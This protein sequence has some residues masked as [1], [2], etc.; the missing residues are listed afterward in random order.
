M[1][2]SRENAARIVSKSAG[3]VSDVDFA[4]DI[5]R[6]WWVSR[7]LHEQLDSVNTDAIFSDLRRE[8][9][10]SEHLSYWDFAVRL[11][12]HLCRLGDGH[13]RV[14]GS[15][16]ESMVRYSSGFY[17]AVT[18]QG[19]ATV[20]APVGSGES[21]PGDL[22]TEVDGQDIT[23]YLRCVN[24]SPGSTI[25]QRNWLAVQSLTYQ[26]RYP[27]ECP[28]P[29]EV[30]LKSATGAR[31]SL[32]LNWR[33][34]GDRAE[35]G[36]CI[37]ASRLDPGFGLVKA[38]SFEC[39]NELGEICDPTFLAQ[40]T[41][42]VET[43]A[44]C[45]TL[46]LDLRR[47]A[48]GRDEQARILAGLLTRKRIEWM[49][50]IHTS[51][52]E[53]AAGAI[54]VCGLENHRTSHLSRH[55]QRFWVLIGPGC[56][57]TAEI[58]VTALR[59]QSLILLAGET[60]AGSVGNPVEF[61]LPYSGLSI[62]VPVTRYFVPGTDVLIEGAGIRPDLHVEQTAADLRRGVDSVLQAVINASGAQMAAV[63]D[64]VARVQ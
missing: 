25:C 56:A 37:R 13:L 51:P 12:D 44:D 63:R 33:K 21:K 40:A 4:H 54:S 58:L 60:T 39:K 36:D 7:S 30:T 55:V 29:K 27:N 10:I 49:R 45:H 50:Y 34:L 23:S 32:P 59:A 14:R 6:R 62:T 42:A 53:E 35:W 61:R 48:G 3:F 43:L 11:R 46:I 15:P 26:E 28:A 8:V 22:V 5:V 9:Q 64:T 20:N 1:A 41:S 38:M 57:S 31:Y 47:N 2:N 19:P 18:Q 17:A 52:C 16:F 24:L